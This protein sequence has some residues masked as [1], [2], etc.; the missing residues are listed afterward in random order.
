MLLFVWGSLLDKA[1]TCQRRGR[2][3]SRCFLCLVGGADGGAEAAGSRVPRVL[4]GSGGE[5]TPE[6][7]S[8][9]GPAGSGRAA[10]PAG[11]AQPLQGPDAGALLK[12]PPPPTMALIGPAP[13]P[14]AAS[15]TRMVMQSVFPVN[16]FIDSCSSLGESTIRSRGRDL[17]PLVAQQSLSYEFTGGS[18]SPSSE[19][20][21]ENKTI[22]LLF[23]K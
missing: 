2:L 8:A 19:Q 21:L 14:E 18:R 13:A 6:G 22:F 12:A 9:G 3:S 10:P 15:I 23:N 16:D 4:Q 7:G 11:G 1:E 5:Q 20:N 17:T